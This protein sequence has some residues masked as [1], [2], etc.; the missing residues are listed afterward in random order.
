MV[1][2]ILNSDHSPTGLKQIQA[3]SAFEI[4]RIRCLLDTFDAQSFET[5]H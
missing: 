5:A 2:I 3:G 1:G 4:P